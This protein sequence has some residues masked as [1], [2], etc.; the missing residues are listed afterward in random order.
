MILTESTGHSLVLKIS[1]HSYFPKFENSGKTIKYSKPHGWKLNERNQ[2]K[3]HIRA[4]G[5]SRQLICLCWTSQRVILPTVTCSLVS[6]PGNRS[7]KHDNVGYIIDNV[8]TCQN[9][10]FETFA[11]SEEKDCLVFF[12]K[13]CNFKTYG[14]SIFKGVF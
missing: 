1:T 7:Q 2:A 6:R 4:K 10:G 14:Q 11:K 8:M 12:L 3:H 13:I 9:V 5:P